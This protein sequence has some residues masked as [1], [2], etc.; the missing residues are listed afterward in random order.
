M[1]RDLDLA[2]AEETLTRLD[3]HL[4][5]D[6]TTAILRA[7]VALA[8]N[9]PHTAVEVLKAAVSIDPDNVAALKLLSVALL[10][11]R[12][13]V[14]ARRV[15]QRAHDLCPDDADSAALLA[16]LPDFE[17]TSTFA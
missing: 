4:P 8:S 16:A 17:G 5:Q 13:T 14:T 11:P 6:T 15:I 2:T 10:H 3:A 12:A 9:A 7:Q 1:V